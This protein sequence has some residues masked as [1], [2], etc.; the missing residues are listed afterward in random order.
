MFIY[1]GGTNV[2]FQVVLGGVLVIKLTN[3][4]YSVQQDH[5]DKLMV[6]QHRKKISVLYKT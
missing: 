1:T 6:I 3:R 5:V 4:T 2:V